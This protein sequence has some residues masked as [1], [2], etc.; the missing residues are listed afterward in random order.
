M[1]RR[2]DPRLDGAARVARAARP[3]SEA[4]A[5]SFHH[6]G[7]TKFA[8]TESWPPVPA[9][10]TVW[11][12]ARAAWRARLQRPKRETRKLLVRSTGPGRV[13]HPRL[14][15]DRCPGS[16]RRSWHP[17]PVPRPTSV[18]R[19]ALRRIKGPALPSR[20]YRGR[21]PLLGLNVY[22]GR[23]CC[24]E[25]LVSRRS[26][27]SAEIRCE[28]SLPSPSR[29]L[30]KAFSIAWACRPGR[31]L[32]SRRVHPIL[33]PTPGSKR[34]RLR[35]STRRRPKTGILAPERRRRARHPRRPFLPTPEPS[36]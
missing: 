8:I 32:S 19:I 7:Q 17:P 5:S 22:R 26:D 10:G 1:A 24:S 28:C 34:R 33:L 2:H 11:C 27:V 18:P 12:P 21:S 36:P 13:G 25:F 30:Q 4:I 16:Q 35:T 31:H 23:T 14:K 6:R 3:Y 29:L 9:E 15:P 20:W